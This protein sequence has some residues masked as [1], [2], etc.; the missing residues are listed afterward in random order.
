MAEKD[1][2]EDIE[3]DEVPRLTTSFFDE[4][5]PRR[6]EL[7]PAEPRSIALCALSHGRGGKA[8]GPGV[9]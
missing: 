8:A 7:L 3:S 2:M 1:S 9:G 6:T 5:L 4:V